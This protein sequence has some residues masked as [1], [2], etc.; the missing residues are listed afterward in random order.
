MAVQIQ[1][2]DLIGKPFKPGG[3]DLNT[4]IDCFGL[5][6]ECHTRSGRPIPDFK[7]PEFHAEMALMLDREKDTWTCHA[8]NRDEVTFEKCIPGRSLL[9]NVRGMACHVGYVHR[10]GH[11][12]H[13][14]ED[15]NGVT[16][17]RLSLWKH[18]IVGIYEFNG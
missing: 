17:A 11:F 2:V 7:S 4:G 9:I 3:R 1:T 8:A 6:M 15:T 14:W 13:A 5:L 16:E 12:I 18:R 10:P